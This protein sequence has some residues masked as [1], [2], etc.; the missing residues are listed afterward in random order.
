MRSFA[1]DMVAHKLKELGLS[2]GGVVLRAVTSQRHTL[3]VALLVANN[4]G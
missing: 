2:H 4:E 3:G 1:R